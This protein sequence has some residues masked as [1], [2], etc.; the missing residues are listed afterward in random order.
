MELKKALSQI[1]PTEEQREKIYGGILEK[2]DG[3]SDSRPET[4]IKKETMIGMKRKTV[5]STAAAAVLAVAMAGGTTYAVSPDVREAVNN[6]LGINRQAAEEY[7]E[8]QNA[9]VGSPAGIEAVEEGVTVTENDFTEFAEG[10]RVKLVSVVNRGSFADIILEFEFDEPVK[11]GEYTIEDLNITAAE[12]P[13]YFSYPHGFL[14]VSEDGKIYSLIT[15]NNIGGIPEDMPIRLEM[16]SLDKANSQNVHN[17]DET[18]GDDQSVKIYGDFSADF[19]LGSPVNTNAVSVEPTE[20]LWTH[21]RMG[22]ATA[23]MEVTAL[24]Y[25]PKEIAVDLRMLED[26]LVMYSDEFGGAQ[27]FNCTQMFFEGMTEG[28]MPIKLKM[29]DG[30]LCDVWFSNVIS[31]AVIYI[32]KS[33][34]VTDMDWTLASRNIYSDKPTTV[35][36][37]LAGITD[38]TDVEAIVFCGEEFPITQKD[39]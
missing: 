2:L 36:F 33:T 34:L 11:E 28:E 37:E 5:F 15:L 25:S 32:D 14:T 9:Y 4:E 22:G 27:Y 20:V 3:V 17:T 29:S 8:I 10:I 7:Y 23:R 16:T 31:D 12:P 35:T 30:S 13:Y 38:Y 21:P 24:K 26:C 18:Y 39:F 1:K 6:L 19:S